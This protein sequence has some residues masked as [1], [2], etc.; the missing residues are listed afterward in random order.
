MLSSMS[1]EAGHG[2]QAMQHAL[3]ALRW[4]P[5]ALRRAQAQVARSVV[6]LYQGQ[7]AGQVRQWLDHA[8]V[9]AEASGNARVQI[10]VL[11]AQALLAVNEY[12]DYAAAEPLVRRCLQLCE[13]CGDWTEFRIRQLDLATCLGWTGR[14]AAAQALLQ[15]SLAAARAA[16]EPG[17]ELPALVQLGRVHLRQRAWAEAEAVLLQAVR[18][19]QDCEQRAYLMW[20]LLHLP[21]A[22]AMRGRA[23]TAALLQG[24]SV[25]AWQRDFGRINRIETR[26]LRRSR[27]L[28]GQALGAVRV[29]ALLQAGGALGLPQVL[30]WLDTPATAQVPGRSAQALS[31]MTTA[32]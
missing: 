3:Q 21:A 29:Q 28:L 7:P 4:A 1:L 24:Y 10:T 19:A 6:W 12:E 27:R 31:G 17:V 13:Q 11:R 8:W 23:E 30:A 25:A 16:A 18:K 26:D 32:T 9:D 20:A 14:E 5:D 15:Q 22:L 2:E